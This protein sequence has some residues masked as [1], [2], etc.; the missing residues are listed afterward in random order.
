MHLF[1][2]CKIS[3]I[4]QLASFC[5]EV[6]TGVISKPLTLFPS[7]LTYTLKFERLREKT[8]DALLKVLTFYSFFYFM[9]IREV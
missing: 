7:I 9:H 6:S 1:T 3:S 4:L 2:D 8:K 5:T